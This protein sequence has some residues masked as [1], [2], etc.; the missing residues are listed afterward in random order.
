MAMLN[1]QMVNGKKR[2]NLDTND[3][4]HLSP[5]EK[6]SEPSILDSTSAVRIGIHWL[7]HPPF[8]SPCVNFERKHDDER[9]KN[10]QNHI[11]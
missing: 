4:R 9:F 7:V 3:K 1:N 2:G 5:S 8:D 6:E 11:E 10:R